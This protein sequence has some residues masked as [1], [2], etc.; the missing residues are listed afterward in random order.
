M[1]SSSKWLLSMNLARV[2][3]RPLSKQWTF[4]KKKK[5]IKANLVEKV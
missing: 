3:P 5:K 4:G 2:I 1:D